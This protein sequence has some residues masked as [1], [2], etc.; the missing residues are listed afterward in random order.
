MAMAMACIPLNGIRLASQL[1]CEEVADRLT[2]NP[3]HTSDPSLL[4]TTDDTPPPYFIYGSR[5]DPWGEEVPL[6]GIPRSRR[7]THQH[8]GNH[9]APLGHLYARDIRGREGEYLIDMVLRKSRGRHT[10]RERGRRRRDKAIKELL[11]DAAELFVHWPSLWE[12]IVHKPTLAL[13][14]VYMATLA[15]PV[16]H[17]RRLR[18]PNITR[19]RVEVFVE[20]IVGL[21]EGLH[22]ALP[23]ALLKIEEEMSD[24]H[25]TRG[26]FKTLGQKVF[27][28]F[29][30]H[31]FIPCREHIH[32][33]LLSLPPST[34]L[35]RGTCMW[36]HFETTHPPAGLPLAQLPR[37]PSALQL[38]ARALTVCSAEGS[39]EAAS[40]GL[41]RLAFGCPGLFAESLL[42]PFLDPAA[43]ACLH[44]C[45][46]EFRMVALAVSREGTG[47]GGGVSLIN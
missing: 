26:G 13:L 36:L 1:V 41:A 40:C 21:W 6:A 3:L 37:S 18:P 43:I 47:G 8:H 27:V 39:T 19:E 29:L 25:G 38:A 33:A 9:R 28:L 17:A 5:I 10:E 24:I 4:P 31:L 34:L 22:A 20:T 35:S 42:L 32:A 7:G 30:R 23:T 46:R 16:A 12:S 44:T 2:G 45:A 11:R 14:D 15:H